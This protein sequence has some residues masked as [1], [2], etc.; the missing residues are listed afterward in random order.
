M[1]QGK[2]TQCTGPRLCL[3]VTYPDRHDSFY[4]NSCPNSVKKRA[5]NAVPMLLDLE[6]YYVRAVTLFAG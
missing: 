5:S 4:A 3:Q 2:Q 1:S 6:V